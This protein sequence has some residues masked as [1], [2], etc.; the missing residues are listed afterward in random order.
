MGVVLAIFLHVGAVYIGAHLAQLEYIDIWRCILVA[1]CSY[2]AMI[3][4][5][6]ALA[7][8]IFVPVLNVFLGAIILGLGTAIATKVVLSC[9]WQPAW[10]VG[11][12]ALAFNLLAGW[13][14]KGCV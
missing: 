9:D 5:A 7:L 2:V 4:C 12:T 13:I 8:L 11:G 10:T 14:A 3:P 1:I 6:I